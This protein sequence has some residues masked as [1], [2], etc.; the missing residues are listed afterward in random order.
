M[1]RISKTYRLSIETIEK[2]EKLRK[3]EPKKE[4]TA[5][6]IIEI[7]IKEKEKK[8]NME[9]KI[10]IDRMDA[11]EFLAM[12]TDAA[13]QSNQTRYLST[14]QI[15]SNIAEDFKELCKLEEYDK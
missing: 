5:T 4:L 2:I 8:I 1:K 14:T 9:E 7:A 11:E 15:I 6:D 3:A 10:I 12:L 13:K